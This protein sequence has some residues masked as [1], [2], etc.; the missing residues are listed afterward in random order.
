MIVIEGRGG[1][2]GVGGG[3]DDN[4]DDFPSVDIFQ[5]GVCKNNI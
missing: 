3:G 5:S 2:P 4:D 1:V